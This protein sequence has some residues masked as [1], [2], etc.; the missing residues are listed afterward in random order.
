MFFSSYVHLDI[1]R[2][3]NPFK[4]FRRRRNISWTPYVRS[5]FI[6]AQGNLNVSRL[7]YFSFGS[8][9]VTA[10]KVSGNLFFIVI[11][12]LILPAYDRQQRTL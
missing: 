4:K 10:P 12:S 5:V 3:L 9:Q 7:E 6:C 2:K 1:G 8:I 11:K